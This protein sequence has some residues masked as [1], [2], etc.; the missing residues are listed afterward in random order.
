MRFG[1]RALVFAA[2]FLI[3]GEALRR[4][5]EREETAAPAVEPTPLPATSADDVSRMSKAALYERAKQLDVKGRSKMSKAE[6]A[7]AVRGAG[8]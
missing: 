7:E 4:W 6:L 8:G 2:G 1:P 5:L 3:G